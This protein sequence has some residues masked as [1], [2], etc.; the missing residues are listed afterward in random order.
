MLGKK[1]FVATITDV[2]IHSLTSFTPVWFLKEAQWPV[3]EL[4]DVYSGHL[5]CSVYIV[6]TASK[7][8]LLPILTLP[9][10]FISSQS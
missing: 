2:C 8:L 3:P 5:L 4:H 10:C 9:Y 6:S 7:F 1:V